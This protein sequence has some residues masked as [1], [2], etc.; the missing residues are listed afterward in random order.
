MGDWIGLSKKELYK[1]MH[2]DLKIESENNT[3][4]TKQH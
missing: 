2:H 1:I 4:I 3:I